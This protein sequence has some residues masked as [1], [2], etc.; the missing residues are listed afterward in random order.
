M[1][2][3]ILEKGGVLA[4]IEVRPTFNKEIKAKKF[5]DESLNELR[6]KIMSCNAQDAALDA[7]GVLSFRGRIC[8]SRVD[9]MIQKMLKKPHCSWYSIHPGMTM[10]YPDL[11]RLYWWP[12]MK[13]DIAKFVAKCQNCQQWERIDMDFVVGLPKTLGKFDSILVVV[14]RLTKSAHF[15]SV[16]VDYDAQHLAK[17]FEARDM[18]PLGVDLVKDAKDNGRSIQPKRLAAQSRQKKYVNCKVKDI[19]FQDGEQVILKVSPIKGMIRFCKKGNLCPRYIWPFKIL[20]TIRPVAYR[21]ALPPS[22]SGV[23]PVFHVSMLK[24]YHGDK[25]YIIK[26]NSVLLDKY[27]QYEEELVAILDGYIRKLRTKE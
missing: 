12:D 18:K 22:L 27:V 25:D 19:T 5:E 20:D 24:K 14:D 26:W 21:L 8:V 11:K 10:M 15:I 6:K 7:G 17:G 9:D 2:L 16:R 23:H 13:K 4:N 1:Q 3:G